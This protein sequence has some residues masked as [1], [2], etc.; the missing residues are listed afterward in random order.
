MKREKGREDERRVQVRGNYEGEKD[1][2]R[3]VDGIGEENKEGKS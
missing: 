2:E 1:E 3:G